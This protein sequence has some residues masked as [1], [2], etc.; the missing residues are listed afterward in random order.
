[1]KIPTSASLRIVCVF[2]LV[3]L[4]VVFLPSA[5]AQGLGDLLVVPT[6][7]VFEGAKRNDMLSLVNR[8]NDTATYAITF[9]QYRMTDEGELKELTDTAGGL[10]ADRM[11]RFFP[12]QVK[13][14]PGESQNVR[15][16]LVRPETL[17]PGEYRSHL[18]FRAIPRKPV[19]DTLNKDTTESALSVKL[20]A[21]FGVSIPVIVRNGDMSATA[22]LADPKIL[23]DPKVSENRVLRLSLTRQGTSS[24]YGDFTVMYTPAGGPEVQVGLLK[25]VSLY[26]PNAKRTVS[27]PLTLAKGTNWTPGKL[28][29]V[30]KSRS[31]LKEAVMA[32]LECEI[33]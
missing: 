10:F 4:S 2:C 7:V 33:P 5:R 28:S 14:V 6:R 29:I 3:L 30:Y 18:Y 23:T 25:G 31:E 8:G 27:I 13:L 17:P 12:K 11:V 24:I 26:T 20:T 16:Q 1:M 22:S 21:I 9:V 19:V 32:Q 15:L